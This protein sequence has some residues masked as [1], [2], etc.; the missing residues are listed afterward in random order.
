MIV[1]VEHQR[2]LYN[3]DGGWAL[4]GEGSDFILN[5]KKRI[6]YEY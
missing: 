5:H 3:G 4:K 1:L 6:L 2:G